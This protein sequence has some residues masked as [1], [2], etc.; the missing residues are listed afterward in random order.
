MAL[1]IIKKTL[2]VHHFNTKLI[3][4]FG[5]NACKQYKRTKA[6]AALN[7]VSK[8]DTECHIC[9]KKGFSRMHTHHSHIQSIHIKV[10]KNQCDLQQASDI[11]DVAPK[12]SVMT[13]GPI[14]ALEN[15][16]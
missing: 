8:G 13:S 11:L 2:K 3:E 14:D 10:T 6:E 5:V 9:G 1:L 4:S 16:T 7:A 12:D 15:G